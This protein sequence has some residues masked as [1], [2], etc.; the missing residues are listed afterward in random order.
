[1]TGGGKTVKKWLNLLKTSDLFAQISDDELLVMLECIRPE[2]EQYS[3]NSFIA[4]AGEPFRG[5]GI[6]LSGTVTVAK[7]DLSGNRSILSLLGP[8]EMFGEMAV[9]SGKKVWPATVVAQTDT[10]VFFLAPEKIVGNCA[11]QCASHRHLILNMLKIISNK[12]LILNKKLEYLSIK[13]VREKIGTF[14]L[15]QYAQ[16][17]QST[18]MLPM[19]RNEM[20]DFLNITRPSLSREMSRLRDEGII[21]FHRS[22]IQLK[23]IE[24]L[25]NMLGSE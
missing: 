22:S 18:F 24:A 20:A 6:V 23:D 15:E 11:R 25:R 16:T 2:I 4:L 19:N 7:E 12:A 21:D 9:F 10:T 14:L 3:K 5:I 13:S 8:G 17:G 1:M